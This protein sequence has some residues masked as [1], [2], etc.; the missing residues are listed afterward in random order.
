MLNKIL[1]KL[2]KVELL[3]VS[4]YFQIEL[5]VPIR[6]EEFIKLCIFGAMLSFHGHCFL[7]SC[8]L[9]HFQKYEEQ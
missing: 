3:I 1:S 8:L 5:K 6:Y 9:D 4:L 7:G 2:Q